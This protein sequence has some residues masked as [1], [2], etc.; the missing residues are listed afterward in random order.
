[1]QP[2][3]V[4]HKMYDKTT[5]KVYFSEKTIDEVKAEGPSCLQRQQK[6]ITSKLKL[7]K[8]DPILGNVRSP[9]HGDHPLVWAHYLR[10]FAGPSNIVCGLTAS[11]MDRFP[12][13]SSISFLD[14]DHSIMRMVPT[15][16]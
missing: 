16:M 15:L 6:A 8:F 9:Q 3:W 12:R 5:R 7:D 11:P 14:F 4:K 2:S 1:M 10:Y 13:E